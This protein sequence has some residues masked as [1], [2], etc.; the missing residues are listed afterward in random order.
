[1][2]SCTPCAVKLVE[3]QQKR[4][5]REEAEN[6]QRALE[7]QAK[8]EQKLSKPSKGVRLCGRASAS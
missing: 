8:L 3:E 7:L 1:M 4:K 2:T 6:A 5:E